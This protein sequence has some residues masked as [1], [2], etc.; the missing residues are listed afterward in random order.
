MKGLSYKS[1]YPFKLF[2]KFLT[3]SNFY[4]RLNKN[5]S[6]SLIKTVYETYDISMIRNIGIIAHIDAGK[7]TT[8]ER[9]LFYSGAINTLGEV[10]DGNTITDYL[11]QERERG[12]TI[13]SAC[14]SFVWKG[15]Q[16]NL[17]DTP[18]HIDFTCEV[19]RS[20]KVMDSA[21]I[22]FDSS[23]GVET[24]TITV[25]NQA[26][27]YKLPMIAFIN[28]IDKIGCSV[29]NTVFQIRKKLGLNPLLLTYPVGEEKNIKGLVDLISFKYI[30]FKDSQ[31]L[32]LIKTDIKESY[33]CLKHLEK[34]KK[35]RESLIE[36][37]SNYD[38]ELFSYL[39]NNENI[40]FTDTNFFTP[41]KL[42]N[43]LRKATIDKKI[44]P[45]VC[46]TSLHNKGIQYLLDCVVFFVPSPQE[47]MISSELK[48]NIINNENEIENVTKI[49]FKDVGK[50]VKFKNNKEKD[51]FFLG[52][53]FK[54]ICNN[55]QIQ[56]YFRVYSGS[57]KKGSQIIYSTIEKSNFK[58]IEK[59]NQILRVNAGELVQL[60]TLNC[61]DI[62]ALI[63]LKN[64]TC[65]TTI[66]NDSSSVNVF[67]DPLFIPDPIFYCSIY[68]KSVSGTA[69]LKKA[70]QSLS[71]EDPSLR[72]NNNKETAQTVISGLGNL[73]L[74]II[75]DR[76]EIEHGIKPILGK[77]KV[78]F[79]EGVK[80]RSKVENIIERDLN[81]N[82][83][84]YEIHL[85]I[86]NNTDDYITI[87]SEL[88]HKCD[89]K[90]IIIEEYKLIDDFETKS[91]ADS[92]DSSE[93]QM[94]SFNQMKEFQ[95]KELI[96]FLKDS[97]RSGFLFGYNL[98]N[99]QV[100]IKSGYFSPNK[101]TNLGI[102]QCI[103]EAVKSGLKL[104]VPC[105]MEPIMYIE[106][107]CKHSVSSKIINEIIRRRGRIESTITEADFKRENNKEFI[108]S[109]LIEDESISTSKNDDDLKSLIKSF[110]P[111]VELIDFPAVLRTISKGEANIFN[112]FFSYEQADEKLQENVLNGSYYNE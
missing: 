86:K 75:K 52:L 56:A 104:A 54:I 23:M 62:G 34:Y 73:H 41:E 51:D 96:I 109:Y 13:R 65:G 97:L 88:V 102:K 77:M 43:V 64:P 53:I 93:I 81:N 83:C 21:I 58:N 42:C 106:I 33:D 100:N 94:K 74:E 69:I 26:K 18:G 22:L 15:H 29:S 101:T 5:N 60:E 90:C 59:V 32:Q 78:S 31:G 45:T 82:R 6:T 111:L 40:D 92:I 99:V 66:L 11:K 35:L 95:Q 72:I 85:E 14:V 87:D 49:S 3:K 84:Y 105:L 28:K 1:R 4:K 55:N 112:E 91:V 36:E 67:L 80:N 10:H 2:S 47:A 63:G 25:C 9:M 16:V 37:L 24:Q 46:G 79:K 12:I 71:L 19:E 57:I 61:G 68:T 20:L 30:T 70:L 39:I 103:S 76:I 17:I 50:L 98:V 27:K 38:E 110:I 44:T 7:T 89:N 107:N 108:Y 8:T 48:L